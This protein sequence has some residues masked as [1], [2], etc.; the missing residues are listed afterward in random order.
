MLFIRDLRHWKIARHL[1]YMG[2]MDFTS[3]RAVF[4]DFDQMIAE[5]RIHRTRNRTDGS[6]ISGFLKSPWKTS[7][8]KPSHQTAVGS[9]GLVYG[10]TRSSVFKTDH[11]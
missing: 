8:R 5:A 9:C 4:D 1:Q 10:I 2:C 6:V 7:D 3:R 11:A